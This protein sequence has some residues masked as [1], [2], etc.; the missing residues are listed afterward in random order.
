M[1]YFFKIFDPKV[2]EKHIFSPKNMCFCDEKP[3]FAT[4]SSK[5][6]KAR[7]IYLFDSS[8]TNIVL[9]GS[10]IKFLTPKFGKYIFF[11]QKFVI[12]YSCFDLCVMHHLSF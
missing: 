4:Q 1:L 3:T 5:N 6:K 8:G 2:W 10:N 9:I 11:H 12:L 7:V